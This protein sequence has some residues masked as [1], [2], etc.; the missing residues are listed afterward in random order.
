[1]IVVHHKNMKI[2]LIL[3]TTDLLKIVANII[4]R[5]TIN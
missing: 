3:K 1:M 5:Y 4:I 2:P